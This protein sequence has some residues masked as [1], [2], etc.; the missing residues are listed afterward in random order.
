MRSCTRLILIFSFYLCEIKKTQHI[1]IRPEFYIRFFH[2]SD[3]AC[4]NLSSNLKGQNHK[5]A[6]ISRTRKVAAW[7]HLVRVTWYPRRLTCNQDSNARQPDK[8]HSPPFN[9]L[10]S[11][12]FSYLENSF[13]KKSTDSTQGKIKNQ[14][15]CLHE[16]QKDLA[17]PVIYS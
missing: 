13:Y 8:Q 12:F 1:F 14:N 3:I 17:F 4:I 7:L 11:S 9:D 15:L 10:I 16:R 2:F 5:M 6:T